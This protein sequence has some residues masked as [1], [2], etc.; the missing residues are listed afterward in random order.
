MI[1]SDIRLYTWVDVE[2]VLLRSQEQEQWPEDLVWARGYWDELVLGIRP[3]TQHSVKTWL[4]E[5]Y[6]PRFQ[7]NGQQGNDCIILE[8]A[9]GNQRTLPIILEET[10]EEPPSP[11]KL[12]PNLARPTVIWQRTEKLQAPDIFPDD[13]P[14][15]VAFHSFKGG[16]GRTIHAL[17][18]AQALINAKQKVLLIDGD[19]EAPG[20]S[21]LLESRL[22]YPPICFA[23]IIALIHGDPSPDAEQT[24]DLATQK[25]QN[26]L[27][28]GIYIL[29]SFR[30]N[31]RLTGLAIKPEHLIKGHKNPFILTDS[32]ALLGKAL[33]V[34]VV[35][36]DLPAGLSE[37]AAGLI[38]DPRVYRI[39][40]S[41]LSGQSIS[42][43]AR[44]LELIAKLAPSTRD[45]DPSPGFIFTKVPPDERAKSLVIE[46]EQTILEAIQPLLGEDSEPIRLTTPFTERLQILSNSWQDVWQHL[47]SSQLIDLLHPLLEWLPDNLN[48]SNQADEPISSQSQ[49]ESLRD[50]ADKMIYAEGAETDDFLVTESLENLANDYRNQIPI[51]VVIG[52]KGSGKTYTFMQI[53]RRKEWQKFRE[54]VGVSNVDSTALIAPIIASN[55]LNDKAKKIVDKGRKDCAKQIGLTPPV[56]DSEI[57]DYIRE[58][59]EQNLHEGQWRDRWLDVIAKSL[60]MTGNGRDLPKYIA[61]NKQKIV[62]VIDGLEDLFQEFAQHKAQ[63]TALRALLQDVPQWLEQ[64]PF[65][66]LGIIIF[67]RQ[68]ILTASVRQNSGQMM[69]RYKPYRLR[70]NEETVLRLVAWV[71]D[72]AKIS[73][74][75]KP[76]ELQDMN[77]AELTETLRPLW[78]KKLGKD[79]SK[80]ARSAPFVIAALSDYNGQIQSRDV[81]RLL[82][83]AAEKSIFIDDKNYWQDRILVPKAIRDSLADCSKAKIEEIELENEPLK[84]VFNKLRQLPEVQ[85]KSPFQLESIG[86]ST[87]DISLLKQNG[88]II[89][90]GDK[91]YVSE[92]FR[93]GLGFSQNAG[94]AKVL[95]LAKRARQRL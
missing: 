55:N 4:Q 26:A 92:I 68:D 95:G 18:L 36:V 82:K 14:P 5:I 7:D 35:L 46:S 44:L 83:I 94:K 24:I 67:V 77:E 71:A 58:G 6:D 64:Q 45:Q 29:P 23:D 9:E 88:V 86:L 78:G 54:D 21:W 63:Q 53:I 93:L 62:A 17:A 76:A 22:P 28:D 51:T 75:L 60:G 59:C 41:T 57:K 10:E 89:A 1:P 31:S 19:L 74:K 43:T 50:I 48:N 2:E 13:L 34:N 42:G 25:I 61:Q 52:A 56:D 79:R 69:S 15:V 30:V 87:E 27:V 65:R 32:L 38:L 3:G 16:V 81:V 80:Q 33:G 70:W 84:R 66:C 8:S 73:L 11:N 91:Y 72:K 39:F 20:I 47:A 37:L 12:I 49:R 40:V 90:D 85:K